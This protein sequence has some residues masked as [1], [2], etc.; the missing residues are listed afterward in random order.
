MERLKRKAERLGMVK[1]IK[2][3][4]LQCMGEQKAGLREERKRGCLRR[5]CL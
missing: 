5:K 1:M 2:M 4:S 3:D